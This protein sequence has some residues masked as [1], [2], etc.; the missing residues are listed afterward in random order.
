MSVKIRIVS[1]LDARGL[2]E[3]EAGL[4]KLKNISDSAF[5]AVAAGAGLAAVG[6][7]KFAFDSIK[8]ASNLAESTN[9]VNVAFGRSAKAVLAIGENSAESLGLAQNEFNEAAVR[10][11]AF[12]ERIAGVGQDTSGFIQDITQRAADFASVFNIDVAEALRVFQ[13]GLAG[14]AE[15]L[16]RFGINLLQS[17]VQAY[18]LANGI[19]EVGSQMTETEKVQARYGLLLESTAKTAGDF[20]NTSDG[21]ANSQRILKAQFTDLQAEIGEALLPAFTDLVQ[22]VG[23]AL[24]PELEKLGEWLRSPEG[25]K[26]IQDLADTVTHLTTQF[27]QNIPTVVNAATQLAVFVTAVKIATTAIQLATAAKVLFNTAIA[28]PLLAPALAVGG[29]TVAFQGLHQELKRNREAATNLS[30]RTAEINAEFARL[31]EL[32]DNNVISFTEYTEQINPL[33]VELSRLEGHLG[34]TSG[35]MGRF[36]NLRLGNVRTEMKLTR[37]EGQRLANQQRELYYAMR[38]ETAPEFG[39]AFKAPDVVTPIV[40]TG[41]SQADMARKQVERILKDANKQIAQAQKT[42]NTSIEQANKNYA[43]S[44]VKLQA[45]FGKR[46]EGIIQSS[47]DRLRNAYQS[48]VQTNIAALFDQQEEKS[49]EGLVKS[50]SDKLTA[51]RNL[52]ANSAQLASQGFSQTFIEQ[53]VSAGT[54]TGNELASAILNSTPEAKQELKTLF[55]SL[56]TESQQGMDALA[57]Q[58][59]TSQGLATQELKNLYQATQTELA[60][61]LLAQ[62][63]TLD[64][65]LLDANDALVESLKTIRESVAEQVADIEGMFGSLE[66]SVDKLM[67]KLDQLIAKYASV[68]DASKVQPS[69]PIAPISVPVVPKVDTSKTTTA[70]KN[71]VQ[72][73]VKDVVTETTKQLGE[74]MAAQQREL[75]FAQ[76][77]LDPSQSLF[78]PVNLPTISPSAMQNTTTLGGVLTASRGTTINVNV[79]TDATQSTAMVGRQVASSLQQYLNTGGNIRNLRDG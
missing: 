25:Q 32:V 67:S 66:R 58:I 37:E 48:A 17:E 5:R 70:V 3:A 4:A 29:L 24:M 60:D 74:R 75:Y 21:L 71:A 52:L 51:S 27:I 36:N 14:E 20:A 12:A 72:S 15:P 79:K 10:F 69:G 63:A 45:D 2:K 65:S 40:S 16:K 55:S 7:G 76:R 64:Q 34:A 22:A 53:I 23:D 77:G 11:S 35:E 57:E 46:L 9:A 6:I 47:Q 43:D 8:A 18:A 62:Q 68:N 28:F 39:T 42:Y 54:E 26:A 1:D 31:K 19:T 13:S 33:I 30:G 50:L 38:G 56:E 44:I 61:A 73:G 41:P 78:A 49:V 59:Y